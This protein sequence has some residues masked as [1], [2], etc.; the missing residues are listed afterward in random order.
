[1]CM[2]VYGCVNVYTYVLF[3]AKCKPHLCMSHNTRVDESCHTYGWTMMSHA[4]HMDEPWHT[5]GWVMPHIWMNHGTR[6]DGS[7]HTYGWDMSQRLHTWMSRQKTH[8]YASFVCLFFTCMWVSFVCVFLHVWVS[9]AGLLLCWYRSLLC[10]FFQID[11]G[12]VCVSLFT[13][14]L[15]QV[16]FH[17]DIGLFCLS[18]FTW[19]WVSFAGLLLC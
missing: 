10:V 19:T 6:V 13:G 8:W 3:I 18:L 4:T 17:L 7:C 14:S 12:L 9:F 1:M 11:V 16:L 2:Y 5:Y 15:L